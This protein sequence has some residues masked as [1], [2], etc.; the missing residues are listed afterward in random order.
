MAELVVYSTTHCGDCKVARHVLDRHD[1]A[2]REVDV[3]R[4]DAARELV[5]DLNGG[6]CTVPTIVFPSGR[7]V[8]EPSARELEAVLENEGL[9]EA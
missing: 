5:L 8:V 3:D 2:Y 9:L 7:V 6:Y 4:D 1:L